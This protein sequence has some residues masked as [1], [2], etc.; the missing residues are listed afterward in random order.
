MEHLGMFD[1]SW[2]NTEICQLFWHHQ[3]VTTWHSVVT[4]RKHQDAW[5][6]KKE[7]PEKTSNSHC[8]NM[9]TIWGCNRT[10]SLGALGILQSKMELF[11]L[12]HLE[13]RWWF[14][15]IF[16]W[17]SCHQHDSDCKILNLHF[18]LAP[19]IKFCNGQFPMEEL[20][21]FPYMHGTRPLQENNKTITF[22]GITFLMKPMWLQ[23]SGAPAKPGPRYLNGFSCDM[24]WDLGPGMSPPGKGGRPGA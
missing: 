21:M 14:H 16:G 11:R 20:N 15:R 1:E 22:R 10:Y 3:V 17:S 4:R 9:T 13:W 18:P 6:T 2:C 24:L 7:H 5:R 23:R 19:Y 8:E 12:G